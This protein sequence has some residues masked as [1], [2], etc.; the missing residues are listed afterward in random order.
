MLNMSFALDGI[1][2]CRHDG[3][4]QPV[5]GLTP[6]ALCFLRCL[7]PALGEFL[8]RASRSRDALRIDMAEMREGERIG[9]V[10]GRVVGSEGV[11]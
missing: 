1:D 11:G 6:E 5:A 2:G 8:F 7:Y 4:D 10:G 3:G 9:R